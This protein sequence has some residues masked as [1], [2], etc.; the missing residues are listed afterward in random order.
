MKSSYVVII[1]W[2]GAG[3]LHNMDQAIGLKRFFPNPG[4]AELKDYE[5]ACRWAE[6]ALAER[7][8]ENV[9]CRH[10]LSNYSGCYCL[11]LRE[12]T[13]A[14]GGQRNAG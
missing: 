1:S 7:Y 9:Y 3:V 14:E 8:P 5:D 4:F 11:F 6:K 12:Q 13:G 10:N 2:T